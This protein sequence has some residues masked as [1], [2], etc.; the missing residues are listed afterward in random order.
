M[1]RALRICGLVGLA[2]WAVSGHAANT[3]QFSQARYIVSESAG[4]LTLPVYRLG[5]SASDVSVD[6]ATSNL[7]ATAGVKY[8]AVSGTLN[9]N[10]GETNR[11]ISVPILNDGAREPSQTFL[12]SLANPTGGAILGTMSNAV[13]SITEND[14][15]IQFVNAA[16]S[17]SE[18]ADQ[19]F[20][21]VVRGDDGPLPASV[22]LATVDGTALA[23][24]DYSGMTNVVP[25]AA[26]EGYK[27]VPI[28]LLRNA[29]PQDNRS[30]QVRLSNPV[31]VSLGGQR[32]ALVTI[33]RDTG[34]RCGSSTCYVSED[35]GAALVKV[36]RSSSLTNTLSTVDYTTADGTGINGSDYQAVSGTLYFGPGETQKLIT[37]PLINDGTK[38]GTKNFHLTL[39]HPTGGATLG[40]PGS[41]LVSILDNDPGLGFETTVYTN[42]WEAANQARLTIL[43]GNDMLGGSITVDYATSDLSAHAGQDYQSATGTL[44]FQPNETIKTLVVPILNGRAGL[45]A[46]TF[47]VNL[48]NPTSGIA[49]GKLSAT[50]SIQGSYSSVAPAFE[51][52][53]RIDSQ[54]GLGLVSWSGGGQLQRADQPQGPWQTLT[55]LQSPSTVQSPFSAGFYRIKHPR[56]VNV[57]VPS[58]Y[59][60][61]Q[62]L[63][64]VIL[65]HGYTGNG[66]DQENYMKFRALADQKPF[67]YCYPDGTVDLTGNRWWNAYFD[68]EA[69]AAQYGEPFVDDAGY[70]RSLI[71]DIAKHFAVDPKRVYIVGH[72]NGGF[73]SY[74]MAWKS[75]DLIAGMASL[76]GPIFCNGCPAPASPVSVLHIHGTADEAVPYTDNIG[77][78]PNTPMYPGAQHIVQI[79]ADYN[80]ATDPVTDPAPSLDLTTDLPGLDTVV[81]RF[82]S[83]PPGGGVELWT[84]VGG[85][86]MPGL[87]PE[88]ASRVI[89]WLLAHPKP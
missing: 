64:L 59:S 28:T 49:L 54:G 58:S 18:T 17:V 21:G 8:V 61:Q 76:A 89:D 42:S 31:A 3:I 68:N 88:F 47:R 41:V 60:P 82:T 78:S 36:V 84:I 32:T 40:S 11:T 39:S 51:P 7:T 66:A 14:A 87:T 85:S 77:V 2:G 22:E 50:V 27:V 43:R 72:S 4:R 86:H 33:A 37:V 5:D 35:G 65:L 16:Y 48:S 75:A 46:K 63:P 6:Y 71:E 79:W 44:T 29:S 23:G 15:G 1:K 62:P 69:E 10:A 83:H 56:P 70:L 55:G 26:G 52:G 34:V 81:T 24:V 9:F 80:G 13:V 19:V 57:Y 53:L 38:E 20:I 74:R 67:L 45:G 25:F 12:V 30:F 73:M